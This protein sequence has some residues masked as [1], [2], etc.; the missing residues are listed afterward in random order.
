M[1]EHHRECQ[2]AR[3]SEPAYSLHG[4]VGVSGPDL[5]SVGSACPRTC[6]SAAAFSL[7]WR[8]RSKRSSVGEASPFVPP[9]GS[10]RPAA[11]SVKGRGSQA[12]GQSSP[13]ASSGYRTARHVAYR[14]KT[15]ESFEYGGTHVIT[16][17]AGPNHARSGWPISDR[18]ALHS[19]V[20][21]SLIPAPGQSRVG[22]DLIPETRNQDPANRSS[23]GR[24]GRR[25]WICNSRGAVANSYITPSI[26]LATHTSASSLHQA[27]PRKAP[28]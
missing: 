7:S 11:A 20:G 15:V 17:W 3:S 14:A 23:F 19:R 1:Q 5:G 6:S 9:R 27:T 28:K 12:A 25:A 8:C 22:G 18:S 26:F 2:K 16:G 4:R 24:Q 13:I 10:W 21:W